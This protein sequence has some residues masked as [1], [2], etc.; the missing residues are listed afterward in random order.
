MPDESLLVK[1]DISEI[2]RQQYAHIGRMNDILYRLPV[3][4]SARFYPWFSITS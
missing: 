2:H 1:V 4:F 3:V